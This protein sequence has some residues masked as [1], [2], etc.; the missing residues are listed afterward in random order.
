MDGLMDDGMRGKKE[1]RRSR[2]V[3]SMTPAHHLSSANLIGEKSYV[4]L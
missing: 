4:L 3:G 2:L 1:R